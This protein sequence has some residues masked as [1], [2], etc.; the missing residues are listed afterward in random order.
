MAAASAVMS[1][2]VMHDYIITAV[3]Y[4]C[5]IVS[6]FKLA[7]SC[8]ARE[9]ILQMVLILYLR[10]HYFIVMVTTGMWKKNVICIRGHAYM[11]EHA[12]THTHTLPLERTHLKAISTVLTPSP[13][14]SMAIIPPT[15][16]VAH[17]DNHC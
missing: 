7:C 16:G 14:I 4:C 6:V 15:P 17:S 10:G 2:V 13:A 11:C 9:D 8:L 12:H 1:W 5:L 3:I